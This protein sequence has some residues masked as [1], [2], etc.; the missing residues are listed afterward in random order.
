MLRI[1]LTLCL[2]G[3]AAAGA[4]AQAKKPAPKKPAP[5]APAKPAPKKPAPAPPKPT[6]KAPQEV[7]LGTVSGKLP[8]D[9]E[10]VPPTGEFRAA[11]YALPKAEG[12]GAQTLLIVF[13]FGKNGGGGVEDNVRR[14]YGMIRQP[15]G[16][17][18]AA[19]AKRGLVER[20]GLRIT[21]VDIPGTYLERPF[22]RSEQFTE[23]PNY[24]MLA[25]IVETTKESGDGPYFIRIVGPAKSVGAGKAGWD[26]FIASLIA[27]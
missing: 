10:T 25:A 12:D 24:R 11:Q 21:T 9:W 13:Y 27:D 4:H 19:V 6:A 3:L 8:G 5:K 17:D 15:D 16:G 26:A 14:W 1:A 22:P 18:T 2:A 23:R 7:K 20:E